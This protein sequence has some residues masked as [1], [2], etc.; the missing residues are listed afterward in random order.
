[1]TSLHVGILL[2]DVDVLHELVL[3]GGDPFI[4]DHL[5]SPFQMAIDLKKTHALDYFIAW[6]YQ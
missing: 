3:G 1:M 6:S 2:E 4:T 5:P